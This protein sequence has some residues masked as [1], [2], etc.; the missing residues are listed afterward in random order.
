[1][2]R[3]DR[4][5]PLIIGRETRAQ[6]R[7]RMNAIRE[8]RKVLA[9]AR[10]EEQKLAH[11]AEDWGPRVALPKGEQRVWAGRSLWSKHRG[12]VFTATTNVLR[13]AYP[14]LAEKGVGIRGPLMGNDLM[15]G[16]G[17]CFDP[18]MAYSDKILT[19]PNITI[20]GVIGTG[21]SSLAK[22]MALRG[23]AFGRNT[24]VPGDV[25][26][27]WSA[28][29][30][31]L[32]GT[33]IRLG[34]SLATRLNPLDEGVRPA[35]TPDGAPM[36]D[37]TWGELV[38]SSRLSLVAS[39]VGTTLE[40]GLRP[41]E[42]T[43]IAAALD[44]VVSSHSTPLISHVVDELLEP[45]G[46][47]ALPAGVKNTD[48][49]R[50]MG[51]DAGNA[52]QRLVSGDLKGLF[53]GPSTVAFDVDSP[54][55]SIDL[56]EFQQD[57]AALPLLMTCTAAWTEAS[58]RDPDARK[59]YIVYDEAHRLMSD[60]SLLHRMKEQ[61]KLA[62]AWGISNVLILHRFSDVDAI[63]DEGS[64]ARALARGLVADT[65]TRI[66]LGQPAEELEN[67][68]NWLGLGS[69]LVDML[70]GWVNAKGRAIWQINQRPF[71]VQ[72]MLTSYELE[73]FDTD[74]RMR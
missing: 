30:R 61:W 62:R 18:W 28:L 9:Q 6:K 15:S 46:S 74:A 65:S 16:S 71:I 38:R 55:M 2:K 5:E 40:R 67:V 17:W 19:N 24:Y 4:V 47:L 70:P 22:S 72:S 52:L 26:G 50:Q 68:K 60:I 33:V 69:E 49:L 44:A 56:S 21:K 36:D 43:A 42:H 37:P 59:R 20:L 73:I 8:L 54:M 48:Q 23:F 1:M 31:V 41:D 11:V 58:L 66:V 39:L 57:S 29:A 7:A 53:D 25:K 45:S 32:G 12:P 63:G 13:V 35:T 34:R 51:W 10:K 3:M 64:A 27:E 14:F